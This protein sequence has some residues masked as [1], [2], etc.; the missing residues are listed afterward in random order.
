VLRKGLPLESALARATSGL[1]RA[2][3]RSLAHL[4]AA[5]TLRWMRDLD[6]LIDRATRQRLPEDAK[7][8]SALRIALVQLL[9][10][11]T[12]PHAAISTAL[13]LVSGGPR[14]L[15]HGVFGTIARSGWSLPPYPSLPLPVE[16]RWRSAWGEEMVGAASRLG[17]RLAPLDISYPAGDPPPFEGIALAP[18]H[19]RVP[20][21]AHVDQL[22]GYAHG[23]WW[24]QDVSAAMP[25]ASLGEGLGRTALDLCAAPGGKTMQLSAAGWKVTALDLSK[26]RLARLSQ[27]LARTGL[28]AQLVEADVMRWS[29][30]S[31]AAAVLLD[32]PCSA[33]GIFRRHPDVLHRASSA[34]LSHFPE[35]QSAMLERVSQWVEPGGALVY[36]VCSLEPEEGEN[37]VARFAG[38]QRDFTLVEERRQLPGAFEEA[39]GADG[40]YFARFSRI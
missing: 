24:V 27:N 38:G 22:P 26:S 20:R 4:I 17:A 14:R 33:T 15:V 11:Q 16:E 2:E 34:A 19:V 29:P 28:E 32:A 23:R 39:G 10:L 30:P 3:D 12:P 25:A 31:R 7:A 18:G 13:P 9:R 5:E 8:R 21:V 37:V 36:A 40:F 6:A 1:P 35:R